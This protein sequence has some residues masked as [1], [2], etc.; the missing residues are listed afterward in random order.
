[1]ERLYKKL[2]YMQEGMYVVGVK[3]RS[4]GE[5]VICVVYSIDYTRAWTYWNENWQYPYAI[6]QWRNGGLHWVGERRMTK[7]GKRYF[8]P[9]PPAHLETAV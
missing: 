8:V 3:P 4:V 2:P 7:K 5:G 9:I 1:L 6:F